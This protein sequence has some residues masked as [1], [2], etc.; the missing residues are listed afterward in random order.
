MADDPRYGEEVRRRMASL[1]GA[2]DLPDGPDV[3]RTR[4]GDREQGAELVLALRVEAG[5][6]AQLAFRAYGC[7]HFLAA[8]SWLTERL[9]GADRDGFEHW[10]WS[11][12]AAALEVPPAKYARLLLLQDA[13]RELSRNWPGAGG[14][15]V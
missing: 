4:A 3:V 14:S 2:G 13:V 8:A 1:P 9:R 5:R 12:A 6:V 10:D 11:E 7:P 15:T